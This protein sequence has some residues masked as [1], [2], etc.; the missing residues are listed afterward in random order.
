MVALLVVAAAL[1]CRARPWRAPTCA[2]R[3]SSCARPASRTPAPRRWPRCRPTPSRS[4]AET[5]PSRFGPLRAKLY[6]PKTHTEGALLLTPG[7]NALGIDEPRLVTF[8]R[9]LASSGFIVLTPEL[10]DL[11]RYLVTARS[12]DMIEDAATVV[13]E[14][15]RPDARATG[16]AWRGSASPA[17]SR[18]S[19][20]AGR[21]SA[22]AWRS[23]SRSAATPTSSGSSATCV[24][25]WNRQPRASTTRRRSRR[26]TTTGWPSS[27]STSPNS[28]CRP[29]RW[30]PLRT[31]ILTFLHASHLA[32]FDRKK[33]EQEFAQARAMEAA[34]AEPGRT[35]LHL[36]NAAGREEPR[37]RGCFRTSPTSA[38]TPR[39]RPTSRRRPDAP[40]FLLHGVEDNV[41]PAV[42][43]LR[44][45]G[46]PRAAHDGARAADAAHQPRRGGPAGD[47]VGGRGPDQVL[48]GNV[49]DGTGCR[50]PAIGRRRA[51]GR[52][53]GAGSPSPSGHFARRPPRGSRH[54]PVLSAGSVS[55][56]MRTRRRRTT[57][58]P[59]ASHIRRTWRVRPSCSVI[60][61]SDW[62]PCWPTPVATSATSAGAVRRPSSTHAAR[63]PVER[64]RV[65]SAANARVVLAR[66]FVARDA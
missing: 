44:L 36:V 55:G 23:S 2:R 20:P 48:G 13:L 63:E 59:T 8:A 21:A 12:T 40:V 14:S 64:V 65:G 50:R 30:K 4:A 11:S 6:T 22:A 1:L 31:G 32:L 10:P 19:Q 51:S 41:V 16:S 27:R 52:E 61:I 53:P 38:T 7:V 34:M 42:E 18:W 3:R 54:M 58:W 15:H 35:F 39:C 46:A 28:S 56:P 49:L 33:A 17:G 60:D 29:T 62:S 45:A 5:V 66:H 9:H 57:G 43:T 24:R 37:G 25:A 26:R 47:D